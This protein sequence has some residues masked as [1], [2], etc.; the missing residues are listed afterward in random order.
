MEKKQNIKRKK[1]LPHNYVIFF[2]KANKLEIPCPVILSVVIG[3]V[4]RRHTHTINF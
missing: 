2:N 3:S 1:E 4:A